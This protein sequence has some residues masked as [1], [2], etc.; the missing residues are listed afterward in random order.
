MTAEPAILQDDDAAAESADGLRTC[1]ASGRRRPKESMVRFVIGPDDRPVPDLEEKLPGRGLWLSAERHM[2]H[3]AC[4]KNLF[5]KR[6]RCRVEVDNELPA[7]L[8]ELLVKRC[9]RWLELARRAGQAVAG[10]DEVSR[11]LPGSPRGILLAAFDGAAGGREKLRRLAGERP[12]YSG[13]GTA[14]LG[15]AFG[16]ERVVHAL[17]LAGGLCDGLERDMVRLGGMR[18]GDAA[19]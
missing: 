3:T 1:I 8:T 2:V 18:A 19:V 5:A 16:R 11:R 12:V 17:V 15:F 9:Q 13:L 10:F 7:R 4:A 14:E 6:A